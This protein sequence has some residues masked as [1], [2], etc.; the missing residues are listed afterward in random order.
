MCGREL[1]FTTTTLVVDECS[2][3]CTGGVAAGVCWGA[4]GTVTLITGGAEGL[5]WH[6]NVTP[7][8]LAPWMDGTRPAPQAVMIAVIELLALIEAGAAVQ[9]T[10]ASAS[11]SP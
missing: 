9:A 8:E 1:C 7:E 10:P 5:A 6:L 11:A 3:S 4:L 2:T